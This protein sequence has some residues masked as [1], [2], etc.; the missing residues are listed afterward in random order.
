MKTKPLDT[1]PLAHTI[2]KALFPC[3]PV[4]TF[5]LLRYNYGPHVALTFSG[6]I[7]L[8]SEHPHCLTWKYIRHENQPAL[9]PIH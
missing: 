8:F 5:E 6:D 7:N 9:W 3:F 2:F 4:L 1:N